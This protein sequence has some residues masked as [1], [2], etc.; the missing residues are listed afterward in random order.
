MRKTLVTL[1]TALLVAGAT[2]VAIAEDST[3]TAEDVASEE[4]ASEETASDLVTAVT[5][6]EILA[7]NEAGLGWATIAKISVLA[8]HSG[9]SA[10]ELL[11]ATPFFDGS[12]EFDFGGAIMDLGPEERA[13][14]RELMRAYRELIKEAAAVLTEAPPEDDRDAESN[15]E[16]A[17]DERDDAKAALIADAF[18]MDL[19]SVLALRAEDIGY[20]ALFKLAA[21]ASAQGVTI[22]ELAASAPRDEDGDIAFGELKKTL[23]EEQLAALAAGPKT[24]GQLV[25]SAKK[26]EHAAD[27]ALKNE[28]K[29]AKKTDKAAEKTAKDTAN[30]AKKAAKSDK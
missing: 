18:G 30:A 11:A 21:F 24:F 29:A 9:V 12:T 8:D 1:L 4:T 23:T 16:E 19:E 28:A 14:L 20:G 10:E 26:A 27:K 15:S 22:E 25:S 6:E 3:G 5:L 2:P 17:P 13:A 7:L